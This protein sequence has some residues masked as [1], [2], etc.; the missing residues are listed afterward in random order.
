M[1][2]I[3]IANSTNLGQNAIL[4]Y[5]E[6]LALDMNGFRPC[7]DSGKYL[8]EIQRDIAEAGSAGISGT[9]TFVLGRASEGAI[10]ASESWALSRTLPSTGSLASIRQ[11]ALR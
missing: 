11:S 10:K 3:L 7:L 5:A 8:A 4:A 9:P 2:D 6:Q 1:R